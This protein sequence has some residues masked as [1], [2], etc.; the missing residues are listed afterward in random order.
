[1]LLD[2]IPIAFDDDLEIQVQLNGL[3]TDKENSLSTIWD[4]ILISFRYNGIPV[5][6]HKSTHDIFQKLDSYYLEHA[7]L[8]IE[9][10]ED[11][12]GI[13]RHCV[14]KNDNLLRSRKKEQ[15]KPDDSTNRTDMDVVM[16]E[17]TVPRALSAQESTSLIDL[18]LSPPEV[19]MNN[20]K[21]IVQSIMQ[22]FADYYNEGYDIKTCL[23]DIV[24][25][26]K[27]S[28]Y[29]CKEVWLFGL[30]FTESPSASNWT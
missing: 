8:L 3:F 13:F 26:S 21:L 6:L 11:I 16:E 1:M 15:N 29:Q 19:H 17:T 30:K 20:W 22:Q 5:G 23:F 9:D 12:I 7:T 24:Q 28:F 14:N 25:N 18:T 27:M 4:F 2:L 10:Y